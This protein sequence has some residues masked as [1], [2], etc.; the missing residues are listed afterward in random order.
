MVSYG[1][2]TW[3]L[4]KSDEQA[5]RI[6]ERKILRTIAGP[7]KEGDM[8]RILFNHELEKIIEGQN[9][10]RHIK[11]QRIRWLGHVERMEE[12][13]MP[14]KIM[15][16]KLYSTRRR[17]SRT[18][19]IEDVTTDLAKM[20]IR[21]WRKRVREREEWRQIVEEAKAYPGL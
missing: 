10:I 2:E 18:T 9:I 4:T 7:K 11:A 12:G 16:G 21:E 1:A 6:F 3:T 13:N 8:W 5:L 17:R 19:W 14:K 15:K 20:E